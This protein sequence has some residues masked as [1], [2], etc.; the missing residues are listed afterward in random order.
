MLNLSSVSILAPSG[1]YISIAKWL[2]LCW[3]AEFVIR[4][5]FLSQFHN[6]FTGYLP[7]LA[8]IMNKSFTFV[9]FPAIKEQY[10]V[11]LVL[12]ISFAGLLHTKAKFRICSYEKFHV[13]RFVFCKKNLCSCN[14]KRSLCSSVA[15]VRRFTK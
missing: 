11:F 1:V 7:I 12:K 2:R 6:W 4:I 3:I 9:E 13:M 15:V 5:Y 14:S 10:D 8:C